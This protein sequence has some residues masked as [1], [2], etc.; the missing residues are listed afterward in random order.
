MFHWDHTNDDD[1]AVVV[2]VNIGALHW[3][4][5]MRYCRARVGPIFDWM[6]LWWMI[7]V[8]MSER[9]MVLIVVVIVVVVYQIDYQYHYNS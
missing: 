9:M 1:D 2:V 3:Y 4:C 6:L 5:Q 7:L 8:T